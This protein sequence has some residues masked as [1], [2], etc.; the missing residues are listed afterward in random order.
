MDRV[1]APQAEPQAV[2]H[3]IA[4]RQVHTVRVDLPL[5]TPPPN[6]DEIVLDIRSHDVSPGGLFR[7][8]R[9]DFEQFMAC[10]IDAHSKITHL[11]K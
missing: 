3:A 6:V 1:R 4:T 2:T 11:D 10:L 7:L 8:A 5:R 9:P